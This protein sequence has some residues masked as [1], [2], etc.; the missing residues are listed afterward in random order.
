MRDVKKAVLSFGFK[1][2]NLK[3]LSFGKPCSFQ[4]Y[5]VERSVATKASSGTNAGNQKNLLRNNT[6]LHFNIKPKPETLN[7]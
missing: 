2:L 7:S 3:F 4:R 1:V 5:A 6:T